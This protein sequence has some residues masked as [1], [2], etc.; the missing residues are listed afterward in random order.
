MNLSFDWQIVKM[1]SKEI[2]L[3][4]YFK[5]PVYVSTGFSPDRLQVTFFNTQKWLQTDDQYQLSV[6]E[7]FFTQKDLPPQVAGL[8]PNYNDVVERLGSYFVI[9]SFVQY[10]TLHVSIDDVLSMVNSL[11]I[12]SHLPLMNFPISSNCLRWFKSYRIIS[13]FEYLPMDVIFARSSFTE[14]D[15]WSK[16]FEW[17]GY[18]TSNFL[19]ILSSQWLYYGIIVAQGLFMVFAHFSGA[20]EQVATQMNLQMMGWFIKMSNIDLWLG[21]TIILMIETFYEVFL[22]SI[23]GLTILVKVPA[24]AYLYQD[25]ISIACN[26]AFIMFIGAFLLATV[27]FTDS[28]RKEQ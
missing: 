8:N 3:Q 20:R 13:S 5:D 7:G 19:L 24:I 27:W 4:L 25:W 10:F 15:P 18:W 21:L 22:G 14:T 23:I 12:T 11:Q 2:Q 9:A 28:V 16:S 6:P 17:A 26:M 1:S